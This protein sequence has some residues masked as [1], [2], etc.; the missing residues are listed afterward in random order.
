MV[1][2]GNDWSTHVF[3]PS[4]VA[5][6]TP[7]F[8]LGSSSPTQS[9]VPGPHEMSCSDVTPFGR[10]CAV[11]ELPPSTVATT[12]FPKIQQSDV[13]AQ[14]TPVGTVPDGRRW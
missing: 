5:T 11:Q 9:V 8:D 13:L 14:V 12:P 7:T 4:V 2:L 10:D 3:P 6:T 1:P